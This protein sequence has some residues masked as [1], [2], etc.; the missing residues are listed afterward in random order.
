MNHH[1]LIKIVFIEAPQWANNLDFLLRLYLSTS[2]KFELNS[3]NIS[4]MSPHIYQDILQVMTVFRK[5]TKNYGRKLSSSLSKN[6][7][8]TAEN[9]QK[10]IL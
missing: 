4:D 6:I 5:F 2:K 7:P 9:L 10:H 8:S 3:M 1:K